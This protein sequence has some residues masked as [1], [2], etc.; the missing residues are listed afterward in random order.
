MLKHSML[1]GYSACFIFIVTTGSY[2]Y[3]C[4]IKLHV[5]VN[6][7][8]SDM[9]SHWLAPY[10]AISLDVETW[11]NGG[12]PLPSYCHGKYKVHFLHI[13]LLVQRHFNEISVSSST[14]TGCVLKLV[15][16]RLPLLT[17]SGGA[18]GHPDRGS[19]F[20]DRGAE[21]SAGSTLPCKL[22]PTT[23]YEGWSISNISNEY[24][25]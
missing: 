10:F 17:Y 20:P 5:A 4:C 3:T 21:V 12:E 23:F 9:F 19:S 7:C 8:V 22:P 13:S 1:S 15:C 25:I 2:W 18:R 16:S 24:H 11:R 14:Y 6:L